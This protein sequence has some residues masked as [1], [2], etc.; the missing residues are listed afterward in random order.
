[1]QAESPSTE[2]SDPSASDDSPPPQATIPPQ[3]P[4]QL[5]RVIARAL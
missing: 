1:M 3:L 5:A 4:E 2:C